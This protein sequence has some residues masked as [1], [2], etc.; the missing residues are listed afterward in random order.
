MKNAGLVSA[1]LGLLVI[2]MSFGYDTAPEGTYN[3]GLMQQQMMFFGLGSVAALGGSIVALIGYAVE[4]M[5]RAG[6]LPSASYTPSKPR[7]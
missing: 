7:S 2:V 4:R 5:E 1:A 6:L 3:I